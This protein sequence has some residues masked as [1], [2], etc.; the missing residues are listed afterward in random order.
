[1]EAEKLELTSQCPTCGTPLRPLE[2]SDEAAVEGRYF[3]T[4]DGQLYCLS[5]LDSGEWML[6]P[7]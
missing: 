2:D 4:P 1:M 5:R 6:L 3:V 7:V